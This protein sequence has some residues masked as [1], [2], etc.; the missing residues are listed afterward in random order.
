[1]FM[2]LLLAFFGLWLSFLAVLILE[3]YK[4]KAPNKHTN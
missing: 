2:T 4:D 3:A 1:M